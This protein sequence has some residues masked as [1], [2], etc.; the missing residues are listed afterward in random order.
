[1]NPRARAPHERSR[2]PAP[3]AAFTPTPQDDGRRFG[4]E[5]V[6][7]CAGISEKL[8]RECEARGLIQGLEQGTDAVGHRYT[9]EHIRV[10]RFARRAYAMGFGM[11]DVARLLALRQDAHRARCEVK[12]SEE[13][14]AMKQVLERLAGLCLGDHQPACPILDELLALHGF[15][16]QWT[17]EARWLPPTASV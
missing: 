10:L 13:L 8:A 14:Q 16:S 6:L 11:T 2:R 17:R 3:H 7:A 12:R 15:A 9:H 4:F 1:M 5:E